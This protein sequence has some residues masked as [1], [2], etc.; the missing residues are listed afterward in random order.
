MRAVRIT[1][2]GGPDVLQVVDDEPEPQP[3]RGTSLLTIDHAG[4]NYADTHQA[5]NTYLAP[6]TLPLVP[7]GEAVGRTDEGRRVVALLG[8]GGYAERAVAADALSFE[9]PDEALMA[10]ALDP[11]AET[12]RGTI[13]YPAPFGV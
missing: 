4:I 10:L 3:G 9:V 6:S 1:E 13:A 8:G 5:E 7:G 2:F 12:P 11:Q